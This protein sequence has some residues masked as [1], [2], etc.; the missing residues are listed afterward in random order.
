[1]SE[2]ISAN[3]NECPLVHEVNEALNSSDIYLQ[4]RIAWSIYTLDLFDKPV[5]SIIKF[6]LNLLDE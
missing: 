3:L 4:L 2:L 6:P 5:E 1:M